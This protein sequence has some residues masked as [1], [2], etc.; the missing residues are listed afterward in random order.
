MTA[1]WDNYGIYVPEGAKIIKSFKHFEGNKRKLEEMQTAAS[2]VI[3]AD[4]IEGY[5]YF[6][7]HPLDFLSL[8]EN[9]H[10]W[11]SCHALDGEYRSGNLNYM[12]DSSTIVCYVKS[13]ED[14]ILPRFP[15]DVPWNN[16]KWRVLLF[17]SDDG[18]SMMAGRQYPFFNRAAQR[19]QAAVQDPLRNGESHVSCSEH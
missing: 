10:N 12:V 4:K 11:R 1:S 13:K 19:L 15:E 3:Q 6:S 7:V 17:L 9:A 2:R 14:T 8:S 16:K 18:Y 5:I